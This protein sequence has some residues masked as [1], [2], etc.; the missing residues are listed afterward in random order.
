[1]GES[2]GLFGRNLNDETMKHLD[3][4]LPVPLSNTDTQLPLTRNQF[5]FIV[6]N[7]NIAGTAP[8]APLVSK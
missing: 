8:I 1:M 2:K 3:S 4:V 6:H 5:D 7:T